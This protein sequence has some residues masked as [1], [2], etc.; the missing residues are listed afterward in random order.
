MT[1][2][3]TTLNSGAPSD[4]LLLHLDSSCYSGVSPIANTLVHLCCDRA[5]V[6]L[7]VRRTYC[8]IDRVIHRF[9]GCEYRKRNTRPIVKIGLRKDVGG[10]PEGH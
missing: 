1:N 10:D 4:L 5:G 6:G 7:C 2:E 8:K 3:N 9:S